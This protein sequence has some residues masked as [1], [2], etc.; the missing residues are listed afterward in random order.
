MRTGTTTGNKVADT[1][2]EE[3]W[4]ALRKAGIV[5]QPT[6]QPPFIVSSSQGAQ[7]AIPG[8]EGPPGPPGEDGTG[9]Y[10]RFFFI[11]GV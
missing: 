2:F 6:T 11:A 9:G 4:L 3:L 8:P 5:T 7:T 1:E 10:A